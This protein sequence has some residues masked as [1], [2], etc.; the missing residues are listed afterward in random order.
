MDE[1]AALSQTIKNH[2]NISELIDVLYDMGI[3]HETIA[4]NA[5]LNALSREAVLKCYRDNRVAEFAK[6]LAR[7]KPAADFSRWGA[8]LPKES[9]PG[10]LRQL[11]NDGFNASEITTMAFDIFYAICD[12]VNATPGKA[13]KVEMVIDHAIK[14]N[15]VIPLMNWVRNNNPNKYSTYFARV[16]KALTAHLQKGVE[17]VPDVPLVSQK[18]PAK[19]GNAISDAVV[20][21]L[22]MY[23]DGLEDGGKLAKRALEVAGLG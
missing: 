22:Q 3:D 19:S 7:R 17:Y 10:V 13:R 1:K 5:S 4:V 18:Q 2:F 20:L 11:L 6:A 8:P 14:N 9:L 21:A 15:G 12:E 16:D 23:A